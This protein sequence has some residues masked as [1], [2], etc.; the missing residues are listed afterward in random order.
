MNWAEA[1]DERVERSRV[2]S[3]SEVGC[4]GLSFVPQRSAI[5]NANFNVDD[6]GI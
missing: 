3:S 2:E 6:L 1:F 4:C 5:S